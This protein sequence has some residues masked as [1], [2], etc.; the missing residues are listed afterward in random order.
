MEHKKPGR[1][2]FDK[3]TVVRVRIPTEDYEAMTGKKAEF[4]RAAV[5]EKLNKDKIGCYANHKE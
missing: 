5:K 1:P 4:I 3:T 2:K